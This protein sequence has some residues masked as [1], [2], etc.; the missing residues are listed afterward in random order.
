MTPYKALT[1]KKPYVSFLR[2]FGYVVYTLVPKEERKKLNHT[3]KKCILMG[4]GTNVMG[5]RLYNFTS[6]KTFYSRDCKFHETDVGLDKE[7]SEPIK[8]VVLEFSEES[9][10]T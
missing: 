7:S 4:Y 8:Y 1:R 6:G 9:N 3:G 2:T 5:Y 10:V